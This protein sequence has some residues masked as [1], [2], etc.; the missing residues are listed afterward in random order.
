MD[1]IW[2]EQGGAA[3][4]RDLWLAIFRSQ[5]R[6]NPDLFAQHDIRRIE[7]ALRHAVQQ[8][9][10]LE[11]IRQRELITR[12]D[13]KARL[14]ETIFVAGIPEVI[15]LGCT[16]A[17][18]VENRD[19]I[20]MKRT[21]EAR[22]LGASWIPFRG[23]KG[24]VGTQQD[25]TDL[26]G[27]RGA[28]LLDHQIAAA[29][30]FDNLQIGGPQTAYRSTDLQFATQL[31]GDAELDRAELVVA[32]GYLSMIAANTGVTWNEGDVSSSV[33]RRYALPGIVQITKPK[34]Q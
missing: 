6:I 31:V 32:Q 13:L 19:L 1:M 4:E 28:V 22:G 11:S 15:H 12:H 14:E 17:D 5:A 9:A 2:T 34:E 3:I 8:E 18:I 29:F 23:I 25:Q 20:R 10:N 30:G 21:L 24:P 7:T 27:R 26:L 16:S 33:V